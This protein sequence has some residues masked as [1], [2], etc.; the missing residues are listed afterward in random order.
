MIKTKLINRMPTYER[1]S[2]LVNEIFTPVSIELENEEIK[3]D[4]LKDQLWIDRATWALDIYEKELGLNSQ[5][6]NIE[7]RRSIIKSKY[8]GVGKVGSD[9]IKKVCDSYTNGDVE[10]TFDGK[11]KIKFTSVYGIPS[12]MD[13]VKQAIDHIKPAH[14]DFDFIYIYT[15][16]DELDKYNNSWQ[17]WDDLNLTWDEFEKYRGDKHA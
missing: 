17:Q 8:R 16:W 9:L 6:E 13:S 14:L 2:Q 12:N 11:I 7:N 1:K 3:I 4:D 15:T 10:V 5:D